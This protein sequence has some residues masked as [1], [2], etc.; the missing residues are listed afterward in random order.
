MIWCPDCAKGVH[1]QENH[2][3]KKEPVADTKG[4]LVE[5]MEGFLS[6]IESTIEKSPSA[7]PK[8]LIID[9]TKKMDNPFVEEMKAFLDDISTAIENPQKTAKDKAAMAKPFV[10]GM[11]AFLEDIDATI[12]KS[13]KETQTT[14]QGKKRKQPVKEGQKKKAKTDMTDE[15]KKKIEKSFVCPFCQMVF[16]RKFNCN[17]HVYLVHEKKSKQLKEIV[18]K[19]EEAG[20]E[21]A[22]TCDGG[23]CVLHLKVYVDHECNN[24]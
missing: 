14:K 2:K 15:E 6:D 16:N 3:V 1:T 20:Q 10:E 19:A 13:D 8:R 17:R 18:E 7:E 12:E 9:E 4:A 23:K 11:K 21:K 22:E 24:Q 5:E